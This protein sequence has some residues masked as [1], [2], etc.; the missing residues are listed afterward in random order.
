MA[1]PKSKGLGDTIAKITEATGIDKAVKFIAGED[2]GCDKRK[3]KLNAIFPYRHNQCLLEH[4]YNWL[5]EYF[6]TTTNEVTASKQ[7]KVLEIYNRVFQIK[8]PS[9]SCSDCFRDVHNELKRVMK[10]YEDEVLH[11]S[12]E[13]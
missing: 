5:V 12:S 4:E 8:K 13:S 10:V 11:S 2:C 7:L 6:K 3:E 1:R 9:T